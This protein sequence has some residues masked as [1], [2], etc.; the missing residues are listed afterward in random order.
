MTDAT[1]TNQLYKNV[2]ITSRYD[3]KVVYLSRTNKSAKYYSQQATNS[4][5]SVKQ[6]SIFTL[7][8]TPFNLQPPQSRN[9]ECSTSL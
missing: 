8:T 3:A 9:F 1:F 6:C 2:F 4:N 7:K 5:K